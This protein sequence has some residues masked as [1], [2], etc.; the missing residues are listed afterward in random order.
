MEE[1]TRLMQL[2]DASSDTIKEGNYLEMCTTIQALYSKIQSQTPTRPDDAIVREWRNNAMKLVEL[3]ECVKNLERRVRSF[4]YLK[5]IT[6][7]VK[8]ESVRRTAMELNIVL[9]ENTIQELRAAG[10]NIP[11]ERKFY[12]EYIAA[13]NDEIASDRAEVQEELA[14]KTTLLE[15]LRQRQRW[16][17]MNYNL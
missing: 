11:D 15:I 8:T 4:N 13:K 9:D 6:E 7:S 2:I 3:R 1:I 14:E 17:M 16:L 5:N 12:K 10:V